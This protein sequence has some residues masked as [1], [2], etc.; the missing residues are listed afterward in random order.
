MIRLKY[1]ANGLILILKSNR[2]VFE[3][4]IFDVEQRETK[5]G[6]IIINFKVTTTFSSC[7]AAL[8]E[9]KDELKF[10]M[11]KKGSGLVRGRIV[12]NNPLP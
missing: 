7:Y 8:S 9:I 3:G 11:I 6:R 2:V 10:D 5:T 1:N 4:Y 12:E